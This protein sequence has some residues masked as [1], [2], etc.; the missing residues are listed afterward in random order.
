MDG[1]KA[2]LTGDYISFAGRE[3]QLGPWSGVVSAI[4]IDPRSMLM[5][6]IFVALGAA[7]L[8][9][10]AGFLTHQTWGKPALLVTSVCSLWYL[11]FGTI[12]GIA[13]LVLLLFFV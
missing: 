1:A 7:T 12:A 4:G 5:K 13:Q 3:G 8:I 2:L 10:A 6:L 11:P 9:A